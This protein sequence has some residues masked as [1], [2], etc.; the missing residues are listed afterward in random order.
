MVEIYEYPLSPGL[1]EHE[2]KGEEPDYELEEIDCD[3][4][5]KRMWKD[6]VRMQKLKEKHKDEEAESYSRQQA[7]RQKKM[8][9]A[10]DSI[11]K[12]M[13]KIMEV[14]KGQ[15]FVYGIVPEKG[16]PVTGSSDSLREWWKEKVCFDKQA[17]LA[18][19]EFM[20]PLLENEDGEVDLISNMYLLYELQDT[21]LG[22]LLSALMQHCAPSQRRFPLDRGLA[23]PW[24]PTGKENWWGE[25]GMSQEHGP[26]PYRKPHDLKKAWKV[27]VLASVIK[28]MS[29]DLN[30][31]RTLVRQ[32]KCLQH[33]M[34]ARESATWS[35]VVNQEEALL[36]LTEKCLKISAEEEEGEAEGSKK[37]EHGS[38]K[39]K[40]VFERE[41]QENTLYACQNSKCQQNEIGVGFVDKNSRGDHE[42]Q[43]SYRAD[44]ESEHSAEENIDLD[45]DSSAWR[46][47]SPTNSTLSS[48]SPPMMSLPS[49]VD[50]S[51]KGGL[52]LQEWMNSELEKVEYGNNSS[53]NESVKEV[54]EVAAGGINAAGVLEDY[55]GFWDV[56]IE[57]LAIDGAFDI[58]RNMEATDVNA[59]QGETTGQ[60]VSSIWDLGYEE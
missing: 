33:K 48:L 16:K 20:A 40:C 60:G 34:T 23:P 45:S 31:V 30:K 26:P 19:A 6:R 55:G 59:L 39:R 5:K 29:S 54:G 42:S 10:Q 43:C 3:G 21:T 14:C 4:L 9:R 8:S 13:V 49:S 58:Q 18:V 27:S 11:L 28:H 17:P 25:Q 7:S 53:A 52:N 12:Y 47:F 22:S 35:K 37:D 50:D 51:N 15:G 57:D 38:E 24:W 44:Q 1:D 32:S 46:S 2:E 36:E 41:V 56:G